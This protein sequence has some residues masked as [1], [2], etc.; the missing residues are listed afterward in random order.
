MQH[1]TGVD[2]VEAAADRFKFEDVC[3]R[4]FD[5]R[6]QFSRCFAF[7]VAEGCSDLNYGEHPC[8]Q[9]FLYRG[10]R[11]LAGAAAG[12][13]HV[14]RIGFTRAARR[15]RRKLFTQILIDRDWR[16]LP[17]GHEPSEGRGFPRIV[18]AP[19]ARLVFDRGEAAEL[20]R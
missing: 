20:N 10:D 4:I 14:E 15:R 9:I 12:N 2:N 17:G 18:V 3:L 7:G 8:A 16:N 11:N 1:A 5:T 13:E 6:C 19:A